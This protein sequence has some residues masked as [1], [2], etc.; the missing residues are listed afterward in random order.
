MLIQPYADSHH[1]PSGP[2]NNRPTALQIVEDQQLVGKWRNRVALVTGCS[3]G[4]IGAEIARAIHTTGADVYITAR[5]IEKGNEVAQSILADGRPGV[6]EV[7]QL[8]LISLDSVRHAAQNI[9]LK[10]KSIHLLVNNAGWCPVLTYEDLTN[11]VN[12]GLGMSL[13]YNSR[14]CG[15][16]FCCELP[17]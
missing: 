10:L 8:D 11:P 12:K 6:V 16:A 2:G 17:R 14:R 3:P 9:L 5:D 7:I 4:S 1:H 15:D 13:V